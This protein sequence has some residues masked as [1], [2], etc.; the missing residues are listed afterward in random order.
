MQKGKLSSALATTAFA[1]CVLVA[2]AYAGGDKDK[3]WICHNGNQL[4][5]V[6]V[7]S[8]NKHAGDHPA[9]DHPSGGKDC[10]DTGEP[11]KPFT[12]RINLDLVPIPAAC[13]AG[14]F[15][16]NG[17]TL[18]AELFVNGEL[19]STDSVSQP[20]VCVPPSPTPAVTNVTVMAPAPA[21]A[22]PEKLRRCHSRRRVTV[23]LSRPVQRLLAASNQTS[24]RAIVAGQVR[25]LPVRDGKI[26]A[27]FA[28]VREGTT[29]VVV[30]VKSGRRTL[31]MT[32]FYILCREGALG[33]TNVPPRNG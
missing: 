17:W 21:V 3:E 22:P 31:N 4:V 6:P 27:N 16:I 19:D 26:V 7:G 32:R 13:Q 24:V 30:R 29:S 28:G 12:G 1:S 8:H 2:P 15:G 33:N 5:D 14:E 25:R 18:T 9:K 23:T 10:D 20:A 11:T